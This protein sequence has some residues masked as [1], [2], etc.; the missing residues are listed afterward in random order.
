MSLIS[1]PLCGKY[2]PLNN[3]HPESLDLTINTVE[4]RGLG[5]GRGFKSTNKAKI[6]FSSPVVG[7]INNR[8]LNLVSLM[9][10]EE[11]ISQEE[12]VKKLQLDNYVPKSEYNSLE[13]DLE[14][15][16]DDLKEAK[17]RFKN[18]KFKF[19]RMARL[20]AKSLHESFET[21][22]SY[23]EYEKEIGD[24]EDDYELDVEE[25]KPISFLEFGVDRLIEN[26]RALRASR[27]S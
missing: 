15:A 7:R 12:I 20:I 14:D 21:W 18:Y 8:L 3:F 13:S 27:G 11:V 5:R 4:M 22:D 24:D 1:C 25:P 10:S 2:T 17:E 9:L 16:N 23:L 6:N 19:G 26:Y